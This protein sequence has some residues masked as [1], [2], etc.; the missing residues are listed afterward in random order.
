MRAVMTYVWE[1]RYWLLPLALV[2]LLVV[3]L[4]QRLWIDSVI[5]GAFLAGFLAFLAVAGRYERSVLHTIEQ[6]QP[7]DGE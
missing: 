5:V 4:V 6:G 1:R 3:F 2:A 7:E